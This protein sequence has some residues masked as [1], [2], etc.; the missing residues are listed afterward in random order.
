MRPRD[1]LTLINP[2][3]ATDLC[4]TQHKAALTHSSQR[5]VLAW[6]SSGSTHR[7]TTWPASR[8]P[9]CLRTQRAPSHIQPSLLCCGPGGSHTLPLCPTHPVS[10]SQRQVLKGTVP[11]SYLELP[12][13]MPPI[14]RF[15]STALGPGSSP[16]SELR[17]QPEG[18]A[19]Q[20]RGPASRVLP[21]PYSIDISILCRETERFVPRRLEVIWQSRDS[22]P[23]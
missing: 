19:P 2:K 5:R 9:S 23:G 3:G 10:G 22:S 1:V 7:K 20:D 18:Q 17:L 4:S 15:L 13:T 6:P 8:T 16:A 11:E 21:L 14:K 12:E